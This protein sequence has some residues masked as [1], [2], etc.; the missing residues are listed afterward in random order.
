M[1]IAIAVFIGIWV[2]FFSIWGY[3]R[4]KKEYASDAKKNAG[5]NS[6]KGDVKE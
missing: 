4:L 1:E 6:V 2:S 3:F 5:K